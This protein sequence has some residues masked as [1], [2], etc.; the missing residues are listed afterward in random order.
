MR[1]LLIVHQRALGSAQ[2]VDRRIFR[3]RSK[4]ASLWKSAPF[5]DDRIFGRVRD[6]TDRVAPPRDRRCRRAVRLLLDEM[7]PATVAEALRIAGVDAVTVARVRPRRPRLRSRGRRETPSCRARRRLWARRCRPPHRRTASPRRADRPVIKG[8]RAAPPGG[9]RS[10]PPSSRP[11]VGRSTIESSTS[12]ALERGEQR[13]RQHGIA[14]ARHGSLKSQ[15]SRESGVDSNEF[16]VSQKSLL[17]RTAMG[18]GG[19][20]PPTSRV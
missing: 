2:T 17:N 3:Q 5:D 11:P 10:P 18:A 12:S 6:R 9:E 13:H 15:T 16:L 7:Y 1:G 20:E 4:Y 14:R 8:P 19:F